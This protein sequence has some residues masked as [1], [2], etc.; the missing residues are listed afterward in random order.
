[1]CIFR[2]YVIDMEAHHCVP[3]ALYEIDIDTDNNGGISLKKKAE[4]PISCKL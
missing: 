2:P 1:M 4:S 3:V